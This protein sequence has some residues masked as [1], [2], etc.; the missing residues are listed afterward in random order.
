MEQ[1]WRVEEPKI[2]PDNFTED[3]LCESIFR[4]EHVR[5]PSGR[6]A[7]PLP[8]RR[9]MSDDTFA[10]SRAVAERRF[11][12]LE[13]K[14]LS[15][16]TLINFYIRFMS[17]YV[18]LGHMSLA[19]SPGCYYIL[20]HAVCRPDD[21]ETKIRVVFDASARSNIGPSLNSCLMPGPKLQQDIVDILMRFRIHRHVFTTDIFKMFR[22]IQVI[23]QYRQYQRIL[24]HD[25]PHHELLEYEL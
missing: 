21:D 19:K 13:R 24:W 12:S 3:G 25:S 20:H 4:N 17:E 16:P 1:F 10:G 14:L 22:Q 2:A 9:P 5:L 6:F 18:S 8:F 7:V 23:L 15:N 11:D